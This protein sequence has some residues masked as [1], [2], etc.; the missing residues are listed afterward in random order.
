MSL[1]QIMAM[2]GIGGTIIVCGVHYLLIGRSRPR[3]GYEVRNVRRYT[4]WERLVHLALMGSFVVLAGTGF[5]ASIGWGGPMSGYLLMVHTVT[6]AVFIVSTGAMMLTWAADHAFV[7]HDG[8]WLRG[9]GCLRTGTELPAGRF[10]A[11]DK[12]FFWLAGLLAA[13]TALS[14]L[15]AMTN[16]LDTAGQTLMYEVHRY[17]SLILVILVIAHA[18]ATTLAKPGTW[19]ALVSGYVSSAWAKRHHPLWDHGA[20]PDRPH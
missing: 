16:L 15:L 1:F 6:G 5:Y 9:G 17:A 18:Y 8:R 4:L 7:R 10:S 20:G 11:G 2:G 19:R 12:I 3:P 14:T 13:A